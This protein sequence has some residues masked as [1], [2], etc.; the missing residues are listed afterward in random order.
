MLRSMP[1]RKLK[2]RFTM[3]LIKL[4]TGN[5]ASGVHL[6]YVG[7]GAA[8]HLCRRI[9]DLGHTNILV[10][11]DTVLKDIGLADQALSNLLDAGLNLYWYADVEPDPTFSH[12]A[13][14]ARIL[15]RN[16]CTV[17]LAVGGG[18]S[19][20]AAKVIACTH[21]SDVVSKDWVGLNKI[22]EDSLPI[23]AIPTTS[24]TGSE[25]TIGAV[26]KDPREQ[27]KVIIAADRLLPRAVAL[28]PDLLLGMPASVTAA[29][30]I[31]ALTHGIE[32]FICV[33]DRGTRSENSRLGVQGVFRWLLR[34]VEYPKDDEARLGM[35]LAAY[36]AGIAINQVNVGNVHAIAHQLG[37]RYGIAHGWANALVLP[38]VLQACIKEAENELAELAV[39][40]GISAARSPAKRAQAFIDAVSHLINKVGIPRT[41]ERI[42]TLDWEDIAHAAM[43]ESDGY[44]SPRLLTKS[45]IIEILKKITV[46]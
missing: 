34:A 31:D 11:T 18:S 44:M 17:V 32:A 30:G 29:T 20:D 14:G 4:V 42:E 7:K 46:S 16:P 43:D 37:A 35:A 22:P 21:S 15:R 8:N 3:F 2:R 45:E 27:L 10:V 28:D 6:S 26:I 38:H 13:D 5:K 12:V 36:H 40:T 24:G 9:V 41:D 39:V 1:I 25:A 23:F 19:I 33:W